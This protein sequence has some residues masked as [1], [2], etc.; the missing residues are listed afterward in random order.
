MKGLSGRRMTLEQPHI[1][2]SSHRW[3]KGELRA[4]GAFQQMA[5]AWIAATRPAAPRGQA[6]KATAMM[7]F[8]VLAP[9]DLQAAVTAGQS[10]LHTPRE[11]LPS[12]LTS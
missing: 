11:I 4:P 9:T 8:S 2:V 1:C 12:S 3:R 10:T 7:V 5:E 6:L